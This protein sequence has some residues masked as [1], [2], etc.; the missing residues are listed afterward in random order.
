MIAMTL[1]G[2]AKSKIGKAQFGKCHLTITPE[3]LKVR[4]RRIFR[5]EKNGG[6]GPTGPP[7]TI[8]IW[9]LIIFPVLS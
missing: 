2:G 5:K 9:F 3:F 7:N 8:L 1:R 4:E 6:R